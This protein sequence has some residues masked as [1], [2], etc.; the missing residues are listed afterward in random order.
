[1]KK[2]LYL[3]IALA[4]AMSLVFSAC[5][6]DEDKP[7]EETFTDVSS[8]YSLPKVAESEEAK[9]NKDLTITAKKSDKTGIIYI[10]LGGSTAAVN[11]TTTVAIPPGAVFDD[12]FAPGTVAT[13][14]K[15]DAPAKGYS[16]FVIKGVIDLTKDGYIK[17]Y[18][19]ALNAASAYLK[20]ITFNY[21]EDNVYRAKAYIGKPA[22]SDSLDGFDIIL[23]GGASPKV[24]TLE[25]TQSGITVTYKIDYSAVDIK[26]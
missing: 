7:D 11:A 19:Q 2:S 5:K 4:V 17:Q 1:M 16:A 3:G 15:P 12:I 18:N 8:S 14:L 21:G 22:A 24:I 10:T 20:D 25:V 13:E 6:D 9:V 26:K 23:W